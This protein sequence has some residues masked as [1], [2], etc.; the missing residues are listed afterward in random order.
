MIARALVFS[1]IL[2]VL[3][4]AS[5][6]WLIDVMAARD[7]ATLALTPFFNLVMVWN[8]GVSFGLFGGDPEETRW[9][10]AGVNVVVSVFLFF[11]MRRAEGPWQRFALAAVI[12]GAIG[13]AVDRVN[14]GQVA[15]FFDFHVAGWHWPAFNVADIAISCG[16]A[17][18]LLDSL[19]GRR[20]G[21][22]NGSHE[23]QS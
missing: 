9:V 7:F 17:I 4:Q 6:A 2:I 3:D 20:L 18:L 14:Y 5:K 16:V 22:R 15:D 11:W 23:N 19:F 21:A 8:P 12:G 13:N 10:L 1:A